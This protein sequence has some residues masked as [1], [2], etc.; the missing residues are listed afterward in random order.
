M[1][2]YIG[3]DPGLKGGIGII[4][5]ET[6]VFPMPITKDGRIS[7]TEL[8]D[9]LLYSEKVNDKFVVIE[10]VHAM[11]RQ[12]VNSMFTFGKGYGAIIAVVEML[13]YPY[14]LVMP[15]IWQCGLC[16][17][18]GGNP[19]QRAAIA[20]QRLFPNV[21]FKATARCKALHDGMIDAL[22]MAEYGRRR[23]L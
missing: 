16:S 3:I 21:N 5:V 7:A 1:K 9:I 22:L 23:E 15:Q 19:K 20:A 4:G 8:R 10:K 17:G 12:G 6:L 14:R 13:G 18:T 2:T 11:H